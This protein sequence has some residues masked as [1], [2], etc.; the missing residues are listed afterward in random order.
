[1]KNW[2]TTRYAFQRQPTDCNL[3]SKCLSSVTLQANIR[4]G[5]PCQSLDGCL[6]HTYQLYDTCLFGCQMSWMAA[7]QCKHQQKARCE[8]A[9]AADEDARQ[10]QACCMSN[11]LMN[12]Y[13]KSSEMIVRDESTGKAMTGN[14][15]P[16][17]PNGRAVVCLLSTHS[18]LTSTSRLT[19]AAKAR[20][21]REAPRVSSGVQ[22]QI[23]REAATHPEAFK[24]SLFKLSRM[25][26][27]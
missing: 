11:P 8:R 27:A 25:H 20:L 13:A 26:T 15:R 18:H 6:M 24:Q 16:T 12:F 21:P 14:R 17:S 1:M 23:S 5:R 22:Q 7:V 4:G 10:Q 19:L 9:T 3:Q 2:A